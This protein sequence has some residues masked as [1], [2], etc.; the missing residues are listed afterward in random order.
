MKDPTRLLDAAID[1]PE[2][3][4]LRAG[5]C[6]EPPPEALTRLAFALGLSTPAPAAA[7][8]GAAVA[9]GSAKLATGW[10][11]LAA[12]GL[13]AIGG[14]SWL[15]TRARPEPLPQ[16]A[17]AAPVQAPPAAAEP[18]AQLELPRTPALAEEIA[19]LDGVRRLL[20]DGQGRAALAALRRYAVEHPEGALRQEAELLRIEAWQRA[21]QPARARALAGRFLADNPDSPHAPRV[22]ELSQRN[23]R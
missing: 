5:A 16:A 1:D 6:E 13:A 4:L 17:R 22:R 23:A 10:L 9:A 20:A 7:D 21:G 15:A 18:A 2:L 11:V 8:G 12:C 3:R 14:A 19:R